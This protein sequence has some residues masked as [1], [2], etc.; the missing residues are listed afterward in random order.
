[1]VFL[2][3]SYIGHSYLTVEEKVCVFQE[4]LDV[5]EVEGVERSRFRG[6]ALEMVIWMV[7][8]N[9]IPYSTRPSMVDLLGHILLLVFEVRA[10]N[11]FL[12]E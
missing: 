8:G 6:V 1:M 12:E 9:S 7:L 10:S 2:R 4:Q 3:K 11:W 5:E